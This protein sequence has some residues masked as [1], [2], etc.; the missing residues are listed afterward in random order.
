M[1]SFCILDTL[2]KGRCP[3]PYMIDSSNLNKIFTIPFIDALNRPT[4]HPLFDIAINQMKF[5]QSNL[6]YRDVFT[7]LYKELDEHYRN[8]YFYK[9]TLLNTMLIQNKESCLVSALTELPVANSK[10]DFMTVDKDDIGVAYE[11]KTDL[12][13]LQRLETQIQDYYKVFSSVYVV[14]GEKHIEEVEAMLQNTNVGIVELTANNKLVYK[15]IAIYDTGHLSHE[16]LF[17]VLRKKEF[18]SIV[19]KY[20]G[21]LPHVSDFVYYR[22]C[23]ELLKQLDIIEFQK[24]VMHC[25]GQRNIV[26]DVDLFVQNVPYELSFYAYFSKKHKGKYDEFASFLDKKISLRK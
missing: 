17:K 14:T 26:K 15:K 1:I 8:E 16:T 7:L 4:Y 18:E 6:T 3:I 19:L 11:I 10:P 25:L 21:E 23:F 20:F 5:S 12:D 9:N 24:E 2:I 13:S 22:T